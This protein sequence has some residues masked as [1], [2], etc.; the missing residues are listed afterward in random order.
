[1]SSE[2][3]GKKSLHVR[4]RVAEQLADAVLKLVGR[5]PP[6][7][8]PVSDSPEHKAEAIILW[9]CKKSATIS[10][11]L[12]IPPGPWG[13]VT[14]IPD[15]ALIW[16]LQARMVADIAAVYGQS[17]ALGREHMLWCLFKHTGA[18]VFRDI[19]VRKGE[20]WLLKKASQVLLKQA[21]QAI[22][23]RL[24]ERALSTSLVRFVPLVGAVGIGLFAYRDTREVGRAAVAMFSAM[25][26]EAASTAAAPA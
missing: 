2:P 5:V 11:S 17:A 8:L 3:S 20:R 10:A 22:G 14:V 16:D 21:A 13:L 19:A 15:L 18:Q 26:G 12:A 9:A 6:S 1:M 4:T 7:N 24:T 25:A 23:V